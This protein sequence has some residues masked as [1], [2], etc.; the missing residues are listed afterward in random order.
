MLFLN[1]CGLNNK[2]L[3]VL[4]NN[5]LPTAYDDKVHFRLKNYSS[6]IQHLKVRFNVYL[7]MKLN[8]YY[9]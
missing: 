1:N 5:N 2:Y 7:L 4:Y 8:Y 9:K 3:V 6:E